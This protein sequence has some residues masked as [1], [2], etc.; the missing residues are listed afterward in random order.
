MLFNSY[1][2]ILFFMPV[3][4]IGYYLLNHYEHEKMA[5]IFLIGASWFFY[6]YFHVNY[7]FILLGSILF[8][9]FIVI[10]MKRSGSALWKRT[11]LWLGIAGNIGLIFYYKY[12]AFFLENM[13]S[14]FSVSIPVKNILMPLGISFF[15]F[16]QISYLIDSYRGETINYSFVD[17]VL[18]VSFFPQLVAGP[19]VTHSE[20]I[21]MFHEKSRKKI[22]QEELAKGIFF[23]S[24]GLFKKVIIADTLGIGADWGFASPLELSGADTLLVSLMYTLQIY[25]DFSGYCDMAYGIAK[26]FHLDLPVNF[27]SPYK[28]VSIADFWKRWHMSL[29]RFLTKYVYI[30]LGGNRKGAC[31]TYINIFLVFLISGIWHGAAWTYILWGI[32]HGVAQCLYR[33]FRKIWDRVPKILACCATFI[34]LDV[35]FIMFR[36]ASV[37]DAMSMFKNIFAWKAGQISERLFQCFDTVE[38]SYLRDHLGFWQRA[39]DS[40]PG[41]HMWLVLGMACCIVFFARNLYEREFCPNVKNALGCIVML[42]WSILSLSGLSAFLYFNF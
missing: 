8:N 28:A 15:T 12:F 7:L 19:I 10:A 38:L 23:F 27:N 35:T 5:H 30:P 40:L 18:F 36:A 2:F 13:N 9:Y 24:A 39:C 37:S 29:T 41:L 25:F 6:A 42:I 34:Y 1:V 33:F 31:R 4:L 21:P 32:L 17:Y 3:T 22:S 26:M 16:Q 20:I 14:L 11:A